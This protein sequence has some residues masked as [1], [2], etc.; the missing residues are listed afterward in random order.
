MDDQSP[1]TANRNPSEQR[2]D[3]AFHELRR[4]LLAARFSTLRR[5][6]LIGTARTL[7]GSALALGLAAA[8]VILWPR[9]WAGCLPR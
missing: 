6:L 2:G 5:W 1:S 3:G 4:S 8:I 7:A 9:S